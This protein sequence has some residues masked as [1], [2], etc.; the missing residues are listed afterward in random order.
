MV[1]AA[2]Q[3]A[4]YQRQRYAVGDGD[5]VNNLYMELVSNWL[6]NSG[7]EA[8]NFPP[9]AHYFNDSRQDG[10]IETEVLIKLNKLS[11]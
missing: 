11:M 7:F 8:D 3:M 5:K 2:G 4:K 1:I 6:T 10:F 9:V